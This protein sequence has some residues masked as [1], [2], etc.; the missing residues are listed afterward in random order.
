MNNFKYA[1]NRENLHYDLEN[2]FMY[3]N[4]SRVK[5]K[6]LYPNKQNEMLF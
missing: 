3:L 6:R 5:N 4:K 1:M 2:I